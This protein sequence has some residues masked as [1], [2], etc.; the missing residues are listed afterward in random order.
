MAHYAVVNPATGSV[1]KEYPT[2]GDA[3]L[4]S[5]LARAHAALGSW[6]RGTSVA[7]RAEI[8]RRVGQLHEERK[9]ELGA[10]IGRDGTSPNYLKVDE[11]FAAIA[12]SL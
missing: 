11:A 9:L 3:D 7:E 10:I 4:D 5:A 6:G 2:I 8:V 12:S 1:V